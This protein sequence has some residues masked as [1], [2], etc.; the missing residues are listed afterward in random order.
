MS[1]IR[2]VILA[3]CIIVFLTSATYLIK[4]FYTNYKAEHDFYK[5]ETL[6]LEDLYKINAD[7]FGWIKIDDTN[8]NFPVMYTPDA[9]EHYLRL[10][11]NGEYS[12]VGTPF[13]DGHTDLEHAQ[14]WMI[15][16]HHVKDGSMFGSLSKYGDDE[17]YWKEHAIIKLNTINYG[18]HEYK[19]FAFGKTTTDAKGFNVYEYL[20]ITDETRY[21][22]Y[23]K[24]LQAL[25]AFN[26]GITPTYGE[27]ILILS[28]CSYHDANGRFVVAAV[29]VDE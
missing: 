19:V 21:N 29:E 2:K 16:G 13:L 17:N 26:T 22:E 23:V 10:N 7:T 24:G 14:N 5:M 27:K 18:N 25:S 1:K 8:V 15:Y 20:N 4:Y 12:I 3:I 28:T 9:P 6:S 11:F